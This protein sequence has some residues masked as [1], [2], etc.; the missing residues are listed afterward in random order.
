M[1]GTE[2]FWEI[3]FLRGIALVL[4]AAFHFLYDLHFFGYKGLELSESFWFF[5]PRFIASMFILLVGVS[6]AISYSLSK[7]RFAG[8]GLFGK[9]LRRGAGIFFWGLVI[10]FV[11]WI[12]V[13]DEYIVF[14]ILQFIGLSI[15]LAYPCLKMRYGNLFLGIACIAAGLYLSSMSFTFPY[16]LFLGF[17]PKGFSTLDYF[18]LLPWFGVV[19]I[20]LF[21]GKNLYPSGVRKFRVP[22][23]SKNFIASF[24]SLLGRHSL[25]VYLAHQPVIIFLLLLAGVVPQGFL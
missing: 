19:L 3:D 5:S 9:Y 10:T 7:G 20:G 22:D 16:L 21:M 4:M 12:Y 13:R 14:G 25:L 8:N 11:S 23:Y 24:F 2:R 1:A 17:V 18:P 6:L 15:V